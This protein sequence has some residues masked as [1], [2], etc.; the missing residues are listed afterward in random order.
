MSDSTTT[1]EVTPP[2]ARRIVL[3]SVNQVLVLVNR[4]PHLAEQMPRFAGL[5]NTPL[6]TA[7]KKSCNCGGKQNITTVDVNKQL[8]E[9]LLSSLTKEDFLQM[10]SILGLD[11]LCYYTRNTTQN[12]LELIC[13]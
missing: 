9:N 6:S 11:E 10:K 5:L 8:T 4:N 7:P 1:T 2:A 13:V 12:K 3:T